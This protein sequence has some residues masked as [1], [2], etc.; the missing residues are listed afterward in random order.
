MKCSH[1]SS[2]RIHQ[3]KI[4]YQARRFFLQM[5]MCV[6]VY[7][8][9]WLMQRNSLSAQRCHILSRLPFGTL[10]LDSC[11]I[12]RTTE[13]LIVVVWSCQPNHHRYSQQKNSKNEKFRF[14]VYDRSTVFVRESKY[15]KT[16]APCSREL[17][18]WTPVQISS[19]M[20]YG[21]RARR[22]SIKSTCP[23]CGR[24]CVW[25]IIM[26]NIQYI[27][28]RRSTWKLH[29]CVEANI[30]AHISVPSGCVTEMY[31]IHIT[32]LLHDSPLF[33]SHFKMRVGM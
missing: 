29:L 25:I 21:K 14:T 24:I 20:L 23:Q 16:N 19:S 4:F 6:C 33:G 15:P 2:K 9:E 11:Q 13:M 10:L 28:L 17:E 30:Q 5:A 1:F 27:H 3:T 18:T 12:P 22:A 32:C 7:L 26:V 31:F 8:C